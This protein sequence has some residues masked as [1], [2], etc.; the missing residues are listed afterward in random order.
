MISHLKKIG[1]TKIGLLGSSYGGIACTMAT[2]KTDDTFL[3]VLI[4]QVS[5]YKALYKIRLS[6]D[7]RKK[8]KEDGFIDSFDLKLSYEYYEDFE[9]NN[10]YESAKNISIPTLIIHGDADVV[11][12]IEQS[13]KL[14]ELIKNS[15]LE[16]LNGAGHSCKINHSK[17]KCLNL[18]ANFIQN[19]SKS[20]I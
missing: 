17:E 14:K 15:K 20:Y 7:E 10:G 4:A 13:I 6:E 8:W 19:I 9:N 3:L 12:P 16:I 1:Y 2:S 18:S 5:D 11:V